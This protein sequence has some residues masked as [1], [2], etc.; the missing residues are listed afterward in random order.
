MPHY[1]PKTA[2]Y[3]TVDD[4]PLTMNTPGCVQSTVPLPDGTLFYIV[5]MFPPGGPSKYCVLPEGEL[6]DKQPNGVTAPNC[7]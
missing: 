3:L 5:Q 7:G 1:A 6:T 4:P 2:V